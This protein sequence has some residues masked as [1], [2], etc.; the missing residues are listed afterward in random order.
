M[1]DRRTFVR[2]AT[3]VALGALATPRFASAALAR[4]ELDRIAGERTPSR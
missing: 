4:G 2:S 1:T 3:G